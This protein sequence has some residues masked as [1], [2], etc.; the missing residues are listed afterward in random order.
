MM[1]RIGAWLFF[2]FALLA[3]TEAFAQAAAPVS[4]FKKDCN[5]LVLNN[6]IARAE[7]LVARDVAYSR[8]TIRHPDSGV[9]VSCLAQY[10]KVASKRGGDIFSGNYRDP[11]SD[12]IGDTMGALGLNFVDSYLFDIPAFAAAIPI[13]KQFL[14]KDVLVGGDADPGSYCQI[15]DLLWHQATQNG[16]IRD[17]LRY[18]S[19][20]E[21]L[22]KEYDGLGDIAVRNLDKDELIMFAVPQTEEDLDGIRLG[23]PDYSGAYTLQDAID[24]TG[25]PAP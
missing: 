5:P 23:V 9:L 11:L 17:K 8:Q 6:V 12:V 21:L 13:I 3:A 18:I 10:A 22:N 25:V 16:T 24:R 15:P 19:F 2:L 20:R 7:A 1:R 4:L 14:G